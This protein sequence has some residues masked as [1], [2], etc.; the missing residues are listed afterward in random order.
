[1]GLSMESGA[2]RGV[3]HVSLSVRD[4]DASLEFYRDVLGFEVLVE[5]FDGTVFDGRQAMVQ[6]GRVMISLQAHRANDGSE[7]DPVRTGLDHLAFHLSDYEDLEGWDRHLTEL[8]V[9]HSEIKPVGRFGSM[10]ELRDPDGLQLELFT[11]AQPPSA[12]AGSGS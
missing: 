2:I 7:F 1:M 5:A 9:P 12:D 3:S 11:P 6:A 8:G 10:I 4:L